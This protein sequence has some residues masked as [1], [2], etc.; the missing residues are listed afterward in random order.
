MSTPQYD[1]LAS[2]VTSASFQTSTTK[3]AQYAP[4]YYAMAQENA[5]WVVQGLLCRSPPPSH[6][7]CNEVLNHNPELLD[8]L[9]ACSALKRPP[10]YPDSSADSIACE[11]LAML[12]GGT[13]A[14]VPFISIIL[15]DRLQTEMK[16]EMKALNDSSSLLISRPEWVGKLM[17]VWKRV[18]DEKVPTIKRYQDRLPLLQC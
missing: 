13:S 1:R 7:F 8:L 14:V 11:A 2:L 15:E 9:F 18:E 10:W 4:R 6:G 3:A 17:A 12:Y 5:M 16:A